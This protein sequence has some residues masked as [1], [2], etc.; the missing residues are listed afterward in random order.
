MDSVVER[1]ERREEERRQSSRP[2]G[3]EV[4]LLSLPPFEG[5]VVRRGGVQVRLRCGW[6]AR[7]LLD[8]AGG[9]RR[10]WADGDE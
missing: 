2:W 8:L 6:L 4:S 5:G 10:S 9:R 1:E 7:R 3:I